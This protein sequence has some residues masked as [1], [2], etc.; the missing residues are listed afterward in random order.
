MKYEVQPNNRPD[1][2]VTV[3]FAGPQISRTAIQQGVTFSVLVE[4]RPYSAVWQKNSEM[5]LLTPLAA[6]SSTDGQAGIPADSPAEALEIPIGIRTMKFQR[7]DGEP[8][9][10]CELELLIPHT[11]GPALPQNFKATT[12]KILPGMTPSSASGTGRRRA[13]L[14]SPILRA[15]I[16][17]KVLSVTVSSGAII[18]QG[19]TIM[20]IEAMKMENRILAPARIRVSAI[21]VQAGSTVSSGDE[22]IHMELADLDPS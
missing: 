13:G 16:T 9:T 4:N 2:S 1:Q 3:E 7:F 17:G 18:E 21:K 12:I 6:R 14:K 10:H 5:L 19:E 15:Q 8:E 20:V 11:D 22:L